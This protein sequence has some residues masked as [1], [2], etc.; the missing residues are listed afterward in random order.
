MADLTLEVSDGNEAFEDVLAEFLANLFGEPCDIRWSDET[1]L[2]TCVNCGE[3]YISIS[4]LSDLVDEA[5]LLA[6]GA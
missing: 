3:S 6:L 4:E 5:T 2:Y 1:G